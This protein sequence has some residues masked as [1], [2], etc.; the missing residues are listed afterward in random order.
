MLSP[1]LVTFT[2]IPYTLPS[3]PTLQPTPTSWPWHSP[4]LGPWIFTRPGAS[5]PTDGWLGHPLLH[6]QLETAL[7]VRISSYCCFSYRV[8]D[9]FSSLGTFSSSF[10]GDPVFHPIADCERPLLFLPCSTM[11]IAALFKIVR[12]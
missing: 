7:G 8:A 4:L 1:F 9:A 3:P 11:F 5:P 2:K 12:S 10:I 6:M